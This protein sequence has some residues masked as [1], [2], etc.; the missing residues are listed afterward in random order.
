LA[1]FQNL[2]DGQKLDELVR[3]L[4]SFTKTNHHFNNIIFTLSNPQMFILS[5]LT[6]SRHKILPHSESKAC[7][8]A[9]PPSMLL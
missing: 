2:E 7:N 5:M 3:L 8:L 6:I 1:K 9:L 4:I